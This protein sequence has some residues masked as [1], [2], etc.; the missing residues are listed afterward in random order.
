MRG[1]LDLPHRLLQVHGPPLER[2]Q[3]ASVRQRQRREPELLRLRKIQKIDL[4][5]F[6]VF[7]SSLVSSPGFES[8]SLSRQFTKDGHLGSWYRCT[9]DQWVLGTELHYIDELIRVVIGICLNR[10]CFLGVLTYLK[11]Q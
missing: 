9:V 4:A 7:L 11:L 10:V 5:S 3:R 1:Q 2:H 6:R 8:R